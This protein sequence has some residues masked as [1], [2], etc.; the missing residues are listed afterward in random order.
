[1]IYS[2]VNLSI[3]FFLLLGECSALANSNSNSKRSK[4]AASLKKSTRGFGTGS[5]K[6]AAAAKNN[7]YTPDTSPTTQ[8]LIAFLLEKECEGIG[9]AAADDEDEEEG[10]GIEIGFSQ[11]TGIRGIFAKQDFQPGEFLC[12][13]PFPTAL[14]VNAEES[15]SFTDVDR[16]LAFLNDYYLDDCPHD[17]KASSDISRS[18][19]P[20][21]DCLP[22]RYDAN[23]NGGGGE[24]GL[25]LFD[26]TPD[27]F[28]PEEI[29]LLEFPRLVHAAEKRKEEIQ[30]VSQ[31][32]PS[33]ISREDLQ[34][35]VWLVKSRSFSILKVRQAQDD[36][37]KIVTKSV[38][39]PFLDMIN[40]SC[41]NNPNAELQVIESSKAA[42]DDDDESFYAL[43]ATR[44]IASNKEITIAYGTGKDSSVDLFLNYG[45][46]PNVNKYDAEFL[47]N[48]KED[49]DCFTTAEQWSTTIKEDEKQLAT[50]AEGPLRNILEFRLRMKRGLNEMK[51]LE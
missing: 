48:S 23:A 22:T 27:F 43:Q 9:N 14:V 39:I 42:A 40:H 12:A 34:F 30:R 18:W 33:S 24:G 13:I 45:F 37:K 36:E 32:L 38:M 8:R 49:D 1:M 6:K 7:L 41:D 47:Q 3:L 29:R 16:G 44:H 51:K 31:S 19:A 50:A 2:F 26:P 35:A 10:G 11:K 4:R 20:Y 17:Q 5:S 46:V 28:T 15:E 25:R 21:L